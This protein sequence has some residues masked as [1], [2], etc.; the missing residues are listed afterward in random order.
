MCL[1]VEASCAC[2]CEQ[3]DGQVRARF[4]CLQ[5]FGSVRSPHDAKRD[6]A[7]SWHRRRHFNCAG[8]GVPVLKMTASEARS[9]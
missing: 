8:M 2:V 7:R 6:N 9:F 3:L 5:L 4:A 1:H